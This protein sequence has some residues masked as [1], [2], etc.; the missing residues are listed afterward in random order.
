MSSL[1]TKINCTLTFDCG[2]FFHSIQLILFLPLVILKWL[3]TVM[4]VV[5]LRLADDAIASGPFRL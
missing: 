1:E 4:A 5:I 3:L 2:S